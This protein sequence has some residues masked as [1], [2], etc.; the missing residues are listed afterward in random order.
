M[1]AFV[2]GFGWNLQAKAAEVEITDKSF[3]CMH[4]GGTKVKKPYI[5]HSDPAKLKEAV[6]IFET[7]S[8]DE[9][10]VGTVLQLVPFEAMVKQ[11]KAKFPNSNGWEFFLLDVSATG[12]K[13]AQRGDTAANQLGNC[14]NCHKGG[15][16]FDYVCSKE[17]G[18]PPIPVT[19][20]MILG[21]QGKDP[22]C[23]AKP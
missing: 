19:D 2:L 14:L 7:N 17:H 5:R 8:N 6:R 23:A 15:V 9:Y 13:I 4:D 10:P 3:G 22:R 21:M 16:K 18:C 1:T 12:T 11:D 20:E